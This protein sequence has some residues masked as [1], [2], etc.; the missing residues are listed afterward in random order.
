MPIEREEFNRAI[1]DLTQLINRGFDATNLRLDQ[2]NG[3]V[4]EHESDIAVLKDR[5]DQNRDG[6]ARYAGWGGVLMSAAA[7]AWQTWTHKP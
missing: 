4:Y 2:L 1:N 7:L 3:R 5:A 6:H